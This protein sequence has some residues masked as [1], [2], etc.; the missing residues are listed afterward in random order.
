MYGSDAVAGVV[1]IITRTN[2]QGAEF[3]ADYGISDRDDGQRKSYHAMWGQSTDKGSIILG[4]NYNKND[5]VSAANRAYSHDALY[6]YNTGYIAHGGSSRT[7]NGYVS[8]PANLAAAYGCGKSKIVTRKS[9]ASGAS[10]TDYR[11]YDSV[12]DAFNYQ[13]VGNY[14]QTPGERTGIFA[15]AHYK[16]SDSVEAFAELFHNK[17]VSQS[18]QAPVPLD[19]LADTLFIPSNQYYNPFGI[20]FGVA[21]DG[22]STNEFKTRL[23]TLGNRFGAFSSTHDLV[24]SGLKGSFSDTSWNWFANAS[25]GKIIQHQTLGNYINYSNL[26]SNFACTVASCDPID[27]FNIEDPKTIALLATARTNYYNSPLDYQMRSGE[28]GTSGSLFELPAGSLQLA[29]GISYRKEYVN[30]TVDS[31]VT[32]NLVRSGDNINLVCSGPGS[33]CSSATQGG[34]NVKEAYAELLVPILKD[35][36]LVQ[37]LNVDLGTRYSKY[38]NFGSTNNWKVAIEFKPIED[39]LIRG[40]VSKVFR[41]PSVSDLFA[42]PSADS[43]TAFDPCGPASLASNPACQGYTFTNTGTGQLSGVVTGSQYANANLGTHVVLT[44]ENGKSF[45]YGFVYDPSWLKGLSVNVDYYRILL[46]NLIVSGPGTAQQVVNQCFNGD[47]QVC[48]LLVRTASGSDKGNIKYVYEAAFNSGNL[49]TQGADF[50][51]HYRLPDTAFGNFRVGLQATYIQ[52][53]D[54]NQGGFD[55]HY[56]GHFDKTFGNLARWRYLGSLDWNWGAF[57]ANY[58]ARV[59]G[60]MKIGYPSAALGNSAA[61][62]DT[63]YGPADPVFH[64]GAQTY[65]NVSLGYNIEPLNTLIQVGVDNLSDKQPP[66]LYMNNVANANT[67]VSNYDTVG[68]YYFVKATIKF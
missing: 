48:S 18:Q 46:N 49:V 12:K 13:A 59:V 47:T 4:L 10:P 19:A 6:K 52:R 15:L 65:H 50:G 55:Q 35:L 58:T 60:S 23:S 27:V 54:I 43:P 25:Y 64:Y 3:G 53:Y 2:Y 40:T 9:G 26:A 42:G 24:T 51:G 66:I 30:S 63:Q 39:L 21:P 44:P 11:C 7:P 34:F 32:T 67:D 45:D 17:T 1:N 56:A 62:L 20:D 57:S 33:V 36:P 5:A 37:S 16:L 68:R 61:Q 38:S 28:A 14:D 8:L 29:A 41:A 31:S 22:T